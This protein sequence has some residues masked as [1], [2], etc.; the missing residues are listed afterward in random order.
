METAQEALAPFIRPRDEVL[1]V[2]KILAAN[3]ASCLGN[4]ALDGPPSPPFALADPPAVLVVPQE[5]RGLQREYLEALNANIRARQEH[6]N[7]EARYDESAATHPGQ[8][9][10][11]LAAHIVALRLQR[12]QARIRAISKSLEILDQRPAASTEFLDPDQILRNS[13]SLP[14]VPKEA[15]SSFVLDKTLSKESLDELLDRLQKSVLRARLLLKKEEYLLAGVRRRSPRPGEGLSSAIKIAALTAARNELISWIE[16][17][18]ASTSG[19]G[20]DRSGEQHTDADQI[21]EARMRVEHQLS[22]IRKKYNK[23]LD[24]RKSL[25]RA[26]SL[27]H[28]LSMEPPMIEASHPAAS[29]CHAQLTA[30]S[31]LLSPYLARLLAASHEQKGLILQKSHLNGT[32]A[33]KAKDTCQLLDHLAEESQLLPKHHMPDRSHHQPRLLGDGLGSTED[34]TVSGR[35]RRWVMA[36]EASKLAT[37]ETVAERTEEGEM[38]LEASARYIDEIGSLLGIQTPSQD[39]H[40]A[41]SEGDGEIWLSQGQTAGHSHNYSNQSK[42]RDAW[43]ILDGGLGVLRPDASDDTL[44]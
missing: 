26:A 12:K 35:S 24:A 6:Q 11:F 39:H 36:A 30:S 1:H 34:S 23:Y 38:A 25:L 28:Q 5:V 42:L 13:P 41:R 14:E 4:A 44:Y 20:V 33:K 2:R 10:D 31:Y 22:T 27:S 17:E 29:P 21:S 7:L 40:V 19:D 18:L 9:V 16:T 15:V 3:L 37:L 32:L 43:S 8:N